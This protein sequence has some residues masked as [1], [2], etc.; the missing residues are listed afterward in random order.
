[1]CGTPVVGFANTGLDDIIINKRNGLLAKNFSYKNLSK[2]ID[3]FINRNSY[4][5]ISIRNTI[6]EK[7]SYKKISAEYINIYKKVINEKN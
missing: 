4:K 7:F 3:Y 5:K 6:V 1:M 2:S